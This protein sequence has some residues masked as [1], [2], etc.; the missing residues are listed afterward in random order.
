MSVICR[1]SRFPLSSSTAAVDVLAGAG[2]VLSFSSGVLSG[3]NPGGRRPERSSLVRSPKRSPR[4]SFGRSPGSAQRSPEDLLVVVGSLVAVVV[5]ESVAA[6]VVVLTKDT[7]RGT[8][9]DKVNIRER[10][11]QQSC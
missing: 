10:H 7:A 9:I 1:N 5:V 4:E 6:C 2:V 11:L 3:L 8:F